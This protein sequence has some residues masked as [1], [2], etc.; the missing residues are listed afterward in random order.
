MGHFVQRRALSDLGAA[1]YGAVLF[2]LGCVSPPDSGTL[3]RALF[4]HA[5]QGS[6]EPVQRHVADQD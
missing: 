2:S 5:E 6:E 3:L 4:S 1:G